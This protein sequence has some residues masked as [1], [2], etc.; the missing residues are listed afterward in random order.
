M[1]Q[2]LRNLSAMLLVT[3]CLIARAIA[4]E[5]PDDAKQA[6]NGVKGPGAAELFDW[7]KQQS[8][9]CID[10]KGERPCALVP[11]TY[12]VRNFPSSPGTKPE[13]VLFQVFYQ[14]DTGNAVTY[15]AALFEREKSGSYAF[16]REIINLAGPIERVAFRQSSV[17]ITTATHRPEDGRCC[18]SG[19]TKWLA[20]FKSGKAR[21]ASG[22]K[23]PGTVEEEQTELVRASQKAGKPLKLDGAWSD[24]DS[25][26]VEID[27][28]KGELFLVD[29]GC[30][31]KSRKASR[32][33]VWNLKLECTS[34]TVPKYKQNARLELVGRNL[35]LYFEGS[36]SFTELARRE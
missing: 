24:V 21:Y 10:G 27:F 14:A 16:R 1:I 13:R 4:E 11:I 33:N 20:D 12:Q 23:S 29:A 31:I 36:T 7:A 5:M 6:W 28:S 15:S 25:G 9:T 34:E 19:K 8:L 22:N 18:P 3:I 2:V 30:K 17:E 26:D 32:K 35:R